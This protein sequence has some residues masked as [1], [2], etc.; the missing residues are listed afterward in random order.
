MRDGG[1]ALWEREFGEQR[2]EW[3]AA[4]EEK[5]EFWPREDG[6]T[7]GRWQLWEERLKS[8]S[9]HW[10]NLEEETR[11][12]AAEASEVVRNTLQET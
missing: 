3:A 6:L 12:V 8:L 2:Y 10:E 5:K 1:W 4:L 11:A 9:A 7:R